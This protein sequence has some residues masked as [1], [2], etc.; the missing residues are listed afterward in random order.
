LAALLYSGCDL[1]RFPETE[2]ADTDFWNTEGD[3]M[4]AANRLYQTLDGYYPLDNRAD[5]SVNQNVDA[6]SSGQR[7]VPNTSGDNWNEPYDNIFTAN[8]ILEKGVKAKVSDE[9]KNRYFAEA[10][11]F[12]AYNYFR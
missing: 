8:N 6:V 12:R 4:N 7:T 2:F 5:E 9:I 10:R 1:D 11:F 3:L